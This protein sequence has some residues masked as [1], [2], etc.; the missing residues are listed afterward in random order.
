MARPRVFGSLAISPMVGPDTVMISPQ[1]VTQLT[2]RGDMAAVVLAPRKEAFQSVSGHGSRRMSKTI[3]LT[4]IG[5]Y[6]AFPFLVNAVNGSGINTVYVFNAF[7]LYILSSALLL[8]YWLRLVWRACFG[9]VEA[10]SENKA[11]IVVMAIMFIVGWGVSP[12][13]AKSVRRSGALIRLNSFGG[14][15][16]CDRLLSDAALLAQKAG[17][18]SKL[19]PKESL[20]DSFRQLGGI[21]ARVSGSSNW[22]V[23]IVTS[24]RPINSG[25]ILTQNS[26]IGRERTSNIE[27]KDRIFRY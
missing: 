26:G 25:W 18:D 7:L 9:G 21:S 20:P 10:F 1:E 19:I 2:L 23:E 14:D 22:T 12:I 8:V 13:V 16:F 11:A 3:H 27:T 6:L 17:G 4:V 5:V 24:G 15:A